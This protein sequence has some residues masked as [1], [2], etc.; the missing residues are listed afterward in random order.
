MDSA[1]PRIEARTQ[2]LK[3]QAQNLKPSAQ[4]KSGITRLEAFPELR[5]EYEKLNKFSV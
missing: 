2:Q 3:A 1:K 5:L 4:P